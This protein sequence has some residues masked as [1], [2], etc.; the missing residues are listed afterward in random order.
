MIT[1]TETVAQEGPGSVAIPSAAGD[2]MYHGFVSQVKAVN[3]DNDAGDRDGS[4]RI[5]RECPIPKPGGLV[6]EILGFKKLSPG[7]VTGA[8][9]VV[10]QQA[11]LEG[12]QRS[13][14]GLDGRPP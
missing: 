8:D 13:R 11:R 1:E 6:G 7:G 12:G 5:P 4:R 10:E 3:V 9:E 2:K 14:D